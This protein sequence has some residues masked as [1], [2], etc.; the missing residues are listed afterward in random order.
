VAADLAHEWCLVTPP[1]AGGVPPG[2]VNAMFRRRAETNV[3]VAEIRTQGLNV[4]LALSRRR[5]LPEVLTAIDAGPGGL[6][7]LGRRCAVRELGWTPSG[8]GHELLP[9]PSTA[10]GVPASDPASRRNTEAP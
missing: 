2:L 1:I 7:A 8:A 4:G 3:V 9:A 5:L 10:H 6:V